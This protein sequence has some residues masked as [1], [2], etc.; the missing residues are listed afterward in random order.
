MTEHSGS[1][2]S[3]AGTGSLP[4]LT[5]VCE[6][7]RLELLRGLASWVDCRA[8][9]HKQYPDEE[10]WQ[11]ER[12]TFAPLFVGEWENSRADIL[13]AAKECAALGEIEIAGRPDVKDMPVHVWDSIVALEGAPVRI[14]DKGYDWI[15][16]RDAIGEAEQEREAP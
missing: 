10:M 14:T 8:R 3:G 2:H 12:Y 5:K 11:G 7:A 16:A 15:K 13:L 9:L 6:N 4:A 1:D